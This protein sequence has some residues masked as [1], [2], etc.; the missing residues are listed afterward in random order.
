MDDPTAAAPAPGLDVER[1]TPWLSAN[2]PGLAAPLCYTF[3]S[4]G[5]SNLTYRID[6]DA[7]RS[8]VL[9]RPPLGGVL[10]TAHDMSREWRV[11]S[12]LSATAVPVPTP[13]AYGDESVLG[14]CFYVMEYVPG[15]IIAEPEEAAV[16]SA[17]ARQTCGHELVRVLALLHALEPR[18]VGLADFG[19]RGDYVARQL[20][21]W[22]AQVH[23]SV[24]RPVPAI[25]ELH[26][27]LASVIPAQQAASI[28]HG[29]YRLGNI[30][31]D[32]S[33]QV[34]AVLDWELSTLGDP[35][36]DVGWL[37]STW[38]QPQEEY[39]GVTAPTV[40]GGFPTRQEMLRAYG[41]L[42]GL[43]TTDIEYYVAFAR[44]RGACIAEGVYARYRAGV[45]GDSVID[46]EKFG[47]NA[48]ERA[49]YALD[50]FRSCY[51]AR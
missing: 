29:D 19:R 16:L 11:I 4:G 50:G 34:R 31:V 28:A 1:L 37:L 20:H 45:M 48:M 32:A 42:S 30:I 35:L 14:A 24:A 44:W 6:D 46:V 47:S 41:E 8:I 12:A 27:L 9:R 39:V 49:E 43:D 26:R 7:G 5:R 3:I 13:L 38:A 18:D 33:G 22:H 51:Q 21:R 17:A 2:V 40:A 23:S 36:A 15:H 10:R 25:D